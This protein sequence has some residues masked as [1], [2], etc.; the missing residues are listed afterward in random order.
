MLY[1][2]TGPLAAF[3]TTVDEVERRTGFDFFSSLDD[4][5][6]NEL[7]SVVRQLPG[8]ATEPRY[9]G[10]R[11]WQ[12]ADRSGASAGAPATPSS[13]CSASLTHPSRSTAALPRLAQT[14]HKRRRTP[15]KA[16]VLYTGP[17]LP[18]EISRQTYAADRR[19][20]YA[21]QVVHRTVTLCYC[22]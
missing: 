18:P 5:E 11:S 17:S 8:Y 3:A 9:S 20:A 21:H 16:S 10:D 22:I 2:F 12:L 1:V 14:F 19:Q 15:G 6:E 7:E 13:R 4:S